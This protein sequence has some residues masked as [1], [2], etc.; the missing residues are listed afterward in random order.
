MA[1]Q[2]PTLTRWGSYK[3]TSA[4]STAFVAGSGGSGTL[5]Q[6]PLYSV[7]IYDFKPWQGPPPT[8]SGND[9]S[10]GVQAVKSGHATLR[11][12][13]VQEDSPLVVNGT[14]SN[15]QTLGTDDVMRR[16]AL[17][18]LV[19]A[20]DYF[21]GD[22]GEL[23][24]QLISNL[25][26]SEAGWINMGIGPDIMPG[27]FTQPAVEVDLSKL[28]GGCR[29]AAIWL[30]S[31][32][33]CYNPAVGTTHVYR[34]VVEDGLPNRCMADILPIS[35]PLTKIKTGA[36]GG[37][38]SGDLTNAVAKVGPLY[39]SRKLRPA[40]TN[41]GDAISGEVRLYDGQVQINQTAFSAGAA[42]A[43]TPT[44]GVPPLGASLVDGISNVVLYAESDAGT[45]AGP[46][47]VSFTGS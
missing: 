29:F 40:I 2:K 7:G 36:W 16:S 23:T 33:V 25:D 24:S 38:G 3:V 30:W 14:S 18:V 6:A 9:W 12:V 13:R 35:V 45:A 41:G 27:F 34:T 44:F 15:I 20:W 46:A 47:I 11:V 26:D 39:A 42:G 21:D 5:G 4:N 43:T 22:F 37:P 32:W 28:A 8:P 17:S 1:H 31:T 19:S 10:R